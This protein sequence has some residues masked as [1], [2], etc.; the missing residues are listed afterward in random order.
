M[1]AE[2]GQA[3]YVT[4]LAD[5]G[6][7]RSFSPRVSGSDGET[8]EQMA[9]QSGYFIRK[10]VIRAVCLDLEWTSEISSAVD[11]TNQR[12]SR[13]VMKFVGAQNDAREFSSARAKLVLHPR[14]L[15][16][17]SSPLLHRGVVVRCHEYGCGAALS[18]RQ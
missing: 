5:S 18:A 13:T 17:R 12:R 11:L 1:I 15:H 6:R 8:G 7:W 4:E 9:C 2:F 14:H 3:A 10:V 16:F